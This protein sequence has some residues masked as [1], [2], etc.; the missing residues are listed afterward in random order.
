MNGYLI[1]EFWEMVSRYIPDDDKE[2]VARGILNSCVYNDIIDFDED[3][4]IINDSGLDYGVDI[5]EYFGDA[6]F[7]S[8]DDEMDYEE[9]NDF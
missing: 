2:A 9:D 6:F 3:M 7:C 5:K 4:S 1:N 8:T